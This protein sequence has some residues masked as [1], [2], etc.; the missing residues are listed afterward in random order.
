MTDNPTKANLG[1]GQN[2]HETKGG[3]E[4]RRHCRVWQSVEIRAVGSP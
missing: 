3:S 1:I 2:L 4:R